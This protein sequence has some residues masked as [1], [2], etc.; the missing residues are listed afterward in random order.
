MKTVLVVEDS[1][2]I[3]MLLKNILSENGYE[4]V[5][6]AATG[7]EAIDK[8]MEYQPDI[9]T[10]DITIPE[11]NGVEASKDI[12]NFYPDAKILIV[13]EVTQQKEIV[14]LLKHGVKDYVI[15]PLIPNKFLST[16]NSIQ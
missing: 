9:I 3:R 16:I 10:I 1:L 5:A 15:K 4:V 2:F 11:L 8:Y 14:N 13:S 7:D 6:E 12:L